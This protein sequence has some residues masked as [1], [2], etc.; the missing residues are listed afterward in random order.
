M[1]ALGSLE[2]IG[3]R[4]GDFYFSTKI[5]IFWKF[6]KIHEN[7]WFW[8]PGI[9]WPCDLS[10]VRRPREIKKYHS[11]GR[12]RR[13][14]VQKQVRNVSSDVPATFCG[15]WR[16]LN[17]VF[18][19]SPKKTHCKKNVQIHQIWSSSSWPLSHEIWLI[20][21]DWSKPAHQNTDQVSG[22]CSEEEIIFLSNTNRQI[23]RGDS[24]LVYQLD[25]PKN[26][27]IR[28]RNFLQIM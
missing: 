10:E 23:D 12:H 9:A 28:V 2:S 6:S 19:K 22:C 5:T 11:G 26:S 8:L 20:C 16:Q 24:V 15:D 18:R 21:I 27:Y 4:F 3:N 7:P 14:R 17:A 1:H 25:F 13:P